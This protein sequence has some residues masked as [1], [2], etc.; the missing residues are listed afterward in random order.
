MERLRHIVEINILLGAWLII[1]PFALR[2]SGSTVELYNDVGLG[3]LLI[4]CSWWILASHWGQIGG[5]ALELLGGLWLVASPFVLHYGR[6]SRVFRGDIAVGIL[7]VIVSAIV[8]W[9]LAT[10]VRRVA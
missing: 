1:A 4:A 6:L 9:M 7:S 10:S 3:V 8:T 2:Y 5:G